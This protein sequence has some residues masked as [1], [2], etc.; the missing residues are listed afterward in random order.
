V[1]KALKIEALPELGLET[2]NLLHIQE[3]YLRQIAHGKPFTAKKKRKSDVAGTGAKIFRQKGTGRAR[4]GE[5]RNPHM[6]GG[7]LAFA[8]QPRLQ[9]KR[10]NKRVRISALRSAVL[11]HIQQGSAYYID[12]ADFNTLPKTKQVAAV[13][14][15]IPGGNSDIC[16]VLSKNSLVWRSTRNIGGVRLITPDHLNVRDLVESENLVFALSALDEYKKLLQLQWLPVLDDDADE[17]GP[18][19]ETAPSKEDEQ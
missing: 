12:G 15:S 19:I 7:G 8:P 1:A 5:R 14:N 4:Q 6:T 18:D 9:H 13:L 10:L 3:S 11:W 2:P 16:L 17:A